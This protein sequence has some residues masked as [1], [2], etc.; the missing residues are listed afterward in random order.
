M[1]HDGCCPAKVL[2]VVGP[3][4]YSTDIM[5]RVVSKEV[6]QGPRCLFVCR[7]LVD[8]VLPV[9]LGSMV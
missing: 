5:V 6:N 9:S 1:L 7:V 2:M 3:A 4:L 8:C